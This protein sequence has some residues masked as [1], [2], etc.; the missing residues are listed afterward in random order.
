MSMDY[1]DYPCQ[2]DHFNGL[3]E[4]IHSDWANE[5]DYCDGCGHACHPSNLIQGRCEDCWDDDWDPEE[6]EAEDYG[7][8]EY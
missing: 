7:D 1:D 2:D 5:L 8:G 6:D 4:E 3:E